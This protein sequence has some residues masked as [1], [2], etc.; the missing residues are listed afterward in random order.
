MKFVMLHVKRTLQYKEVCYES[1]QNLEDSGPPF[2]S[3]TI[4]KIRQ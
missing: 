1:W 4:P 3:A 2:Q